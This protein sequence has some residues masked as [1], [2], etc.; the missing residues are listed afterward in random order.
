MKYRTFRNI[1]LGSGLLVAGGAITYV[2]TRPDAPK[3]SANLPP[4]AP[5]TGHVEFLLQRLGTPAQDDKLKDALGSGAKVNLY[6]EGGRWYRAKVDLDRDEKWDEKW[7]LKDGVVKREVSSADDETYN[8]ALTFRDGAWQGDG[9]PPAAQAPAAPSAPAAAPAPG[10]RD[11]DNAVLAALKQ[12]VKDK[13]KDATG[14][15]AFKVNLY[16]DDG[17]RFNRAKVD[18]DRDEK[19]DEKW[20]IREDGSVEREVAPG[21][22]ENYQQTW[23]LRGGTWQAK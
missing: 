19:W 1:V 7:E 14:K 21:D 4:V 22:D 11:V 8:R 13:V 2:A 6:A 23:A 12:P 16:S 20:T 10:L 17:K 3:K 5:G 9:A 18:L 15:T